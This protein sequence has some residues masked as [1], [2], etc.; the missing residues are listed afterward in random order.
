MNRQ[1]FLGSTDLRIVHSLLSNY[2]VPTKIPNGIKLHRIKCQDDLILIE[3]GTL[4]TSDECDEIISNINDKNF[5]DMSNKYDNEKRNSSRLIVMDDRLG[6]TLYRRLKFSNKLTKLIQNI[7]PLGFNVQGEWKINGVNPAMRL[8]K[9]KNGDH[10]SPHKDAQY[11]PSGDERSLLSLI[12]YLNDNYENSETKFYF[13]KNL[14]KSNIKGLTIA[15]EIQSYDGL[16]EG[17]ECVV[18]KPKKGFAILFTHNLLHEAM[19]PEISD[20]RH[21][22]QRLILRTDVLVKRKDKPIGFAICSEEKEDYLACLNFFREAQQMELMKMSENSDD[23]TTKDSTVG[24]LYERSLSIRYCY[25]RLLQSKLKYSN[26]NKDSEKSLMDRLSTELWLEISKFFDEKDFQNLIFAFPHFQ[27]LKIVW[28]SQKTKEFITDPFRPKYLPTINTQYGS[29]TLFSFNDSDFF[30]GHIDGC[31]RVAAV[32]AFFLLGHGK[33]STSYIVRYDENTQQVCEVQMERVLAD[34][35]YNRNCYGS[36]YRVQQ[37]DR[38]KR[39]SMIDLDHSVDRVYVTNRHQSQFIGQDLL[40]RFHFKTRD[41]HSTTS[42]IFGMEELDDSQE[43]QKSN[44]KIDD[45]MIEVYERQ[46]AL[47][48]RKNKLVDHSFD[49]TGDLRNDEDS[50][51]R[52]HQHLIEQ[53]PA[54]TGLFR[55]ISAKDHFIAIVRECYRTNKCRLSSIRNMIRYYNHLVFDF[56]T[57]QLTVERLSNEMSSN[58]DSDSL[59]YDCVKLLEES[60]TEENPIS[61]YRVNIEQLAKET[62]GFNHA[63]FQSSY[64]AVN[65]DHFSFLDY[66]HLSHVH[67]AV[68]QNNNSVFVLT[69][70]GG[71]V[72]I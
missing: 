56:D 26:E 20:S 51:T 21:Q 22:N 32:Y 5:E 68:A 42:D 29:R 17:F 40:S 53:G 14:P 54:G 50:V 13:P 16:D 47:L 55:M 44:E 45:N 66:T 48:D 67:L 38:I 37:K 41:L 30:Y 24:E 11:A 63:A 62:K 4:L 10:F 65:I 1:R 52:Y 69:T 46:H 58:I 31:C 61:F 27:L 35:F 72:A 70:Y 12:I 9:Y 19:P 43:S 36:L 6:R 28:D 34:A 71:I 7:T 59:L 33:D 8:N 23:I 18:V 2:N 15:E 25:P 64:P 57:H 3:L 39:E 49:S 60:T